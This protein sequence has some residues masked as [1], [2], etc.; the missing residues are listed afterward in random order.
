M[1]STHPFEQEEVMAYLDGEITADRAT[2]IALHLKHCTECQE[3]AVSLRN[4]SQ[5][6]AAWEIESSP[7]RLTEQIAAA[8]QKLSATAATLELTPLQRFLGMLFS[9]RASP[10]AWAT[11]GALAIILAVVVGTPNLL[12][13]RIAAHDAALIGSERLKLQEMDRRL[14]EQ[15]LASSPEKNVPLDGRAFAK[16][17]SPVASS[18]QQTG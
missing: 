15:R 9:Q 4:L 13:S 18:A 2:E 6:F 5:Q 7:A 17:A 10:W 12:R 3:L 11:A 14:E 8:T 16:V 1:R